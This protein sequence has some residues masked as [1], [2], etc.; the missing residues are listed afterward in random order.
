MKKWRSATA[1]LN[2]NEANGLTCLNSSRT[3]SS[4]PPSSK[5]TLEL[6]TTSEIICENI[7][8]TCVFD[9]LPVLRAKRWWGWKVVRCTTIEEPPLKASNFANNALADTAL[10]S[11][12][13]NWYHL[14]Y[15]E[16]T[17]GTDQDMV[18]SGW[19]VLVDNESPRSQ[20][21][22]LHC[23]KRSSDPFLTSDLYSCILDSLMKLQMFLCVVCSV[24]TLW[25]SLILKMFWESCLTPVG[26]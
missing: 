5:S 10:L 9:M 25:F 15:A 3:C 11:V 18:I 2:G 22:P 17:E 12:E 16:V 14:C 21:S 7:V 4:T 1:S 6:S 20:S 8:P 26:I 24:K 13:T 23:P 19:F